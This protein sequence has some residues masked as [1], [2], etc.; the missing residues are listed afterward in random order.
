L[1]DY[2]EIWYCLITR[3]PIHCERSRSRSRESRS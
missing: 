2:A 3:Q 1:I